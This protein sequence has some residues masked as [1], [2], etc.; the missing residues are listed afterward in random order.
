MTMK[1]SENPETRTY[2][3]RGIA[4]AQKNAAKP[5]GQS[6]NRS[7]NEPTKLTKPRKS[8]GPGKKRR[9]YYQNNSKDWQI[10]KLAKSNDRLR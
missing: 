5:I 9:K 2:S 4:H 3:K 7:S 1:E 8:P 6:E 10:V